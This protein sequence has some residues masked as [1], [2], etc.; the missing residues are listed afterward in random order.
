MA[1][2]KGFKLIFWIILIFVLL[3]NTNVIPPSKEP[4]M[5]DIGA[6]V[7]AGTFAR[8]VAVC[9]A[10]GGKSPGFQLVDDRCQIVCVKDGIKTGE[11]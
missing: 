2:H 8:L 10:D 3:V 4:V 5:C 7:S 6:S 9:L 11:S 1:K